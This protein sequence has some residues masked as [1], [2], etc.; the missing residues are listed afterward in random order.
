MVGSGFTP[1]SVA[2]WFNIQVMPPNNAGYAI[3]VRLHQDSEFAL[4]WMLSAP[5]SLQ[6][7][8]REHMVTAVAWNTTLPIGTWHHITV[9]YSGGNKDS[10]FIYYIDGELQLSVMN[11]GVAGD[12]ANSN[13]FGI[14][15][16]S[17]EGYPRGFWN[18]TMQHISIYRYALTASDII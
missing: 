7:M 11:I 5:M 12:Y 9:I 4:L 10:S 16:P 17:V 15:D 13:M 2:L 14:N 3:L 6:A 1:F 8:F 18:G